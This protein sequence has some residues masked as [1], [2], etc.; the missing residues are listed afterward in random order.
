M[1]PITR[2]QIFTKEKKGGEISFYIDFD[3]KISFTPFFSHFVVNVKCMKAALSIYYSLSPLKFVFSSPSSYFLTFLVI[4]A[5]QQ[6]FSCNHGFENNI[7][8]KKKNS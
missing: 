4:L 3:A 1:K 7:I 8:F 2:C 5:F 6:P